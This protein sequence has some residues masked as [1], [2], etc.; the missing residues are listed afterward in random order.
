ME[1]VN[2]TNSFR[3]LLQKIIEMTL[4]VSSAVGG[5]GPKIR[6]AGNDP[7]FKDQ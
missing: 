5:M 3:P 1:T 4:M 7:K 2:E 6:P